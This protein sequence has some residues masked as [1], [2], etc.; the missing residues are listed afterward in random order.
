[1]ESKNEVER[2]LYS[3]LAALVD[4]VNRRTY[5]KKL[6]REESNEMETHDSALASKL[7]DQ[8]KEEVAWKKVSERILRDAMTDITYVMEVRLNSGELDY[9]LAQRIPQP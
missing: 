9:R 4:E 1:M 6:P 7:L 5:G 2:R 8:I 3:D